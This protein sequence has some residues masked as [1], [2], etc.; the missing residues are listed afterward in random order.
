MFMAAGT[1]ATR[2]LK[3]E[4]IVDVKKYMPHEVHHSVTQND[5]IFQHQAT[6]PV[7]T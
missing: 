7:K 3:K 5:H 6:T 2:D 1:L 4:T